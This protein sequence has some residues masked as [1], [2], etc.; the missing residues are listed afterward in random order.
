[1]ESLF[2]HYMKFKGSHLTAFLKHEEFHYVLYML[3]A[4]R[5]FY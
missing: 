1:M 3:I 4:K 2:N 5:L